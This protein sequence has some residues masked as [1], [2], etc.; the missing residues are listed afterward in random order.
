MLSQELQTIR[1]WSQVTWGFVVFR[2]W[3]TF[4]N[5]YSTVPL[6]HLNHRLIIF[7]GKFLNWNVVEM[8]SVS[9]YHFKMWYKIIRFH[10]FDGFMNI[11]NIWKGRV[12][13]FGF[14]F[15]LLSVHYLLSKMY[16]FSHLWL[17]GK[18]GLGGMNIIYLLIIF[19]TGFFRHPL[20]T[21]P[22]QCKI[23]IEAELSLRYLGM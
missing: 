17:T 1:N 12:F 11:D 14:G 8:S 20:P 6:D 15:F 3:K 19:I 2:S 7:R 5:K 23:V 22:T 18:W 9:V 21:K 13:L 10:C 4:K 16:L